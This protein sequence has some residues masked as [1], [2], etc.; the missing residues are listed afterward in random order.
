MEMNLSKC[1]GLE[2]SFYNCL[3]LFNR[4]LKEKNGAGKLCH[5][6]GQITEYNLPFLCPGR[7][8]LAERSSLICHPSS[9]QNHEDI[10]RYQQQ[11]NEL[12][13]NPAITAENNAFVKDVSSI[14]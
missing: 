2:D 14:I 6:R 5:H 9:K 4:A 7:R 13:M 11:M 1:L 3:F 8:G 10:M 12:N